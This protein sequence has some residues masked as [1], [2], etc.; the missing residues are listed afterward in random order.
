M[1]NDIDLDLDLVRALH[2]ENDE[3]RDAAREQARVDLLNAI[4]AG[5][6][7]APPIPASRRR[8]LIAF[9]G[10]AT[11][12]LAALIVAILLL[13]ATS[14]T[15]PAYALTRHSDGTLTLKFYRLTTDIPALNARLAKMGIDE[16]VV[17]VTPQCTNQAPIYPVG[18]AQS[19]ITLYVGR[20]YL[21]PGFQGVLGAERLP[22]GR[23][24]LVQGA[25]EPWAIPSCFA[26]V[27]NTDITVVPNGSSG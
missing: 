14:E 13:T 18:S 19:T 17:P 1:S 24:A 6:G 22:N 5:G 3:G 25:L 23:I 27:A 26:T 4:D 16:T 2:P 21:A 10:A 7:V 8:R 11:A 15:S 12:L 20:K 9:G